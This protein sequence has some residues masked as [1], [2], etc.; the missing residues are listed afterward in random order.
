MQVYVRNQL[1]RARLAY[2]IGVCYVLYKGWPH[3]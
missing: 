1:Q 2:V 3:R